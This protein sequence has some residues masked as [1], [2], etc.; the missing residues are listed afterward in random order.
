MTPTIADSTLLQTIT[1]FRNPAVRE[2][3]SALVAAPPEVFEEN[4]QASLQKLSDSVGEDQHSGDLLVIARAFLVAYAAHNGVV[5]KSGEPY[6]V[7]PIEVANV[8][9]LM[10]LDGETIAAGLLHD[11]VEDTDVTLDQLEELFG[12]RV[13]Q[14]VD[15]TTKL[16]KIQWLPD[17]EDVSN[18]QERERE[19]QAESLRKMFL[20]MVDDIGVVLIKL[21]DRLH[22]MRTLGSMRRD[23]QVRIAQQTMEIY[24]PLANRLGIWQVKSE[25][26]DLAFMYLYPVEYNHITS[27]LERRGKDSD[28]ALQQVVDE[29]RRLLS[30]AGIRAELY[31]RQK[32]IYSIYRKMNRKNRAFDEIYDVIGIRIIVDDVTQCYSAL[33]LVHGKWHPVPGEIDDYIATPKE[34]MYQ[35]LHTAVIGPG[36]HPVEIQIRTW[37][38]H[39]VAEYGIAAH[40]RYKEGSKSDQRLEA[41]ITWLRQLMD[42]RDEVADAE[43]FVE[44]LKSDVFQDMI[45]CFTPAGDIIELPRGATPID[46]AYR[47]HTEVGHHTVGASV[48]SQQVDLKYVLNNAQIVEIRTSKT[49]KGPRRDWLQL[50]NGYVKTAS[51]REKIR[52]WFRR[53]E[54]DENISSG[55]STLEKELQRLALNIKHEEVMAKYPRYTKLD[56]FYAAIGYGAISSHSITSRLDVSIKDV[57]PAPSVYKAPSKPARVEVMG[58]G[59]VLTMQANCC[60]PVP[61]EPIV[62]YITRGRGVVYHRQDCPNV[63]HIPDPERLVNVSWGSQAN[64]THPV[65]IIIEA[66]DRVGL[67]KD[68]STLLADQRVNILSMATQTHDDRTVTF[69]A[70]VEVEDLNQLSNMLSKLE[71]LRQVN[72][73][74]READ[75]VRTA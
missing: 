58:A 54:R 28:I 1:S 33:G 29:L 3:E 70:V 74:R 30:D 34:S 25:L 35:S 46:F 18:R 45:Y 69:R 13:A 26:E 4:V 57:M 64:E 53:Q 63:T 48:N 23:K 47:I 62:G 68:I 66:E 31:G 22:N 9:A 8:L 41:K 5:R 42:W 65:S 37:E 11:V 12:E 72:S 43:E 52:Q 55:K 50:E 73:V 44:S 71:Q 49:V 17:S 59:N 61:P 14:L 67:L 32:H 24:A 56:D 15:G 36:G 60:K 27:E 2:S 7:H 21:A 19:Q 75:R 38:M 40:W 39:H 51:A 10:R 20:A 6:I 16:G